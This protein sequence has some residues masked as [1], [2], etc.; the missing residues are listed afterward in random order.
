M[1]KVQKGETSKVQNVET[2]KVQKVNTSKLQ[3]VETLKVQNVETLN[4]QKVKTS[5]C[6]QPTSHYRCQKCDRSFDSK[7]ELLEHTRKSHGNK[8]QRHGCQFCQKKYALKKSLEDHQKAVHQ[9]SKWTCK[10]CPGN[11][12]LRDI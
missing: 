12:H 8:I 5:K 1:S 6:P 4:G 3:N 11:S 9:G 2:S 7:F 10:E